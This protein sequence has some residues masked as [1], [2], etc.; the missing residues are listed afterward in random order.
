MVSIIPV[1][2]ISFSGETK[3]DIFHV[4]SRSTGI[5]L[6]G[7]QNRRF[8]GREKAFLRI[9]N[10]RILD[11]IYD[12]FR[13]IFEEIILVTNSPEK[14]LD[15]DFHIV[16]DIYNIPC[17]LSGIHAGLFHATKPYAFCTACDT[18][19]LKKELVEAILEKISPGFDLITPQTSLGFEPLCAVYSTRSTTAIERSLDKNECKIQDVFKTKRIKPVSEKYLRKIDTDLISFF[20][21][22][23]P[24]DLERAQNYNGTTGEAL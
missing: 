19:F 12:V 20:N 11:Y 17:S 7:G 5:I 23:T 8:S 4:Q 24:E 10:R 9:G 14:Y 21:I 3:K 1:I 18:P 22:N 15:W 13:Q 6:A 16:T 2:D